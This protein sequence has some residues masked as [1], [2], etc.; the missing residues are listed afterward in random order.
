MLDRMLLLPVGLWRCAATSVVG[1][2]LAFRGTA[3]HRTQPWAGKDRLDG[4]ERSLLPGRDEASTRA[5]YTHI[6]LQC[7]SKM[8]ATGQKNQSRFGDFEEEKIAL[9]RCSS[10]GRHRRICSADG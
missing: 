10:I 3:I 8:C 4:L 9:K 6:G 7:S 5:N 1:R 2:I